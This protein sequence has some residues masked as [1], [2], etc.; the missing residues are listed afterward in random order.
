[1]PAAAGSRASLPV[2]RGPSSIEGRPQQCGH[3]D[4]GHAQDHQIIVTGRINR[5]P[6]RA[7]TQ[8]ISVLSSEQIA[9]TGEGD[10][11]GALGR[12]TGL[13][14]VGNGVRLVRGLG[15]RYSLALLNGLPLP[16]PRA[17]EPRGPARH[18]PDQRDRLVAGAE[19]LFGQLPRRIR[20]RRDQ[21]HHPRDSGRE[22]PLDKRRC[23]WRYRN[24]LP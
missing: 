9:R 20:R 7:S 1:M 12:V 17:S 11:A 4:E 24:H 8:V 18:L 15:D 23:V 13:S 10:I 19:D 3:T 21:P 16:S 5:D 2:L 22:L 14:V 6:T